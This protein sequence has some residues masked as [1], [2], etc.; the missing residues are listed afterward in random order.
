MVELD[1]R[2]RIASPPVFRHERTPPPIS[3]HHFTPSRPG[4]RRAPGVARRY[5]V[6]MADRR[7]VVRAPGGLLVRRT[8]R[9]SVRRAV[10]NPSLIPRPL[11]APLFRLFELCDEQI[12][13]ALE[14]DG[15]IAAR[16]R[17]PE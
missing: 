8:G 6:L 17:V 3:F 2:P 5:D 4:N 10:S 15:Q 7:G 9:V 13:G 1:E 16:V 14:Y 12:H 11:R